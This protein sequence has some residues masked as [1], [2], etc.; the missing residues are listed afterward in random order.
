MGLPLT[1]GGLGTREEAVVLV[2]ASNTVL[3]QGL[4]R[5]RTHVTLAQ[6]EPP[7]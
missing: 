7:K 3:S 1:A 5:S 6:G 4:A 2:C